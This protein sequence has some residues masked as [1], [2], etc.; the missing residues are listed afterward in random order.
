MDAQILNSNLCRNLGPN[1]NLNLLPD[2]PRGQA[3]REGTHV[4]VQP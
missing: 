1:L 2:L 4:V 3:F